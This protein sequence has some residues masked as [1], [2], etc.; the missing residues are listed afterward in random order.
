M[1][2]LK[3]TFTVELTEEEVRIITDAMNDKY[4]ATMDDGEKVI[5]RKLRKC[6]GGMIHRY[7]YGCDM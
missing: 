4:H 6:F 5:A 7:F 1:K 3:K 2:A